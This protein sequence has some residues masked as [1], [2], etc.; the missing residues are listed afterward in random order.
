MKFFLFFLLLFSNISFADEIKSSDVVDN[1]SNISDGTVNIQ[2]ASIEERKPE[3][4]T[5]F[6]MQFQE[7]MKKYK[8]T[9]LSFPHKIQHSV[10]SGFI[11]FKNGL[12][13]T[14]SHIINNAF[15]ILVTF[16]D[17]TK[18]NADVV[19]NDQRE[20]IALLKVEK[21]PLSSRYVKIGDSDNIKVGDEIWTSG[22]PLGLEQTLTR[23]IISHL[24]RKLQGADSVFNDY[25]QIDAP[26]NHGNSGGPLFNSH[27]E[28]IGMN[29]MIISTT[30]NS[31]GLGFAIPSK[32][33]NFVSYELGLFHHFLNRR[34]GIKITN[35][36]EDNS[37]IYNMDKS[38][39]L[40]VDV[41]KNYPAYG[42][43]EKNDIILSIDNINMLDTSDVIKT[44]YL[45]TPEDIIKIKILRNGKEIEKELKIIIDL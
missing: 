3:D 1:I 7:S 13:L 37:I 11:L 25:I 12:I 23:G 28:V 20:D 2:V 31:I 40:V 19:G 18:E 33:L 5:P 44:L 4:Y 6:D 29:S 38:G 8:K 26:M 10:G 39:V 34:I 21:I 42:I 41:L 14:N 45:H 9:N 17:G 16:S 35:L 24:H 15:D 27:M 22:S 43:L 36:N 32:Y 30:G